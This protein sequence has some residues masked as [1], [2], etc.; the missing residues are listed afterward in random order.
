MVWVYRPSLAG[1]VFFGQVDDRDV[2][3]IRECLGLYNHPDVEPPFDFLFDVSAYSG[4]SPGA[5]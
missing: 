3:R 2:P 5:F 1:Y 4:I